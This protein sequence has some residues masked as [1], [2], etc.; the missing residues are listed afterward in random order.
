MTQG[1]LSVEQLEA[2]ESN[3]VAEQQ[4]RRTEAK[5]TYY[6]P[7]ERHATLDLAYCDE[8]P[9]IDVFHEILTRLN[10]TGGPLMLTFTPLLGMSEVVRRFMLEESPQRTIIKMA[11]QDAEHYTDEVRSNIEAQYPEHMR[12]IR[13][14]GIP[15]FGAGLV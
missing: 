4:R 8:E 2:F 7:Y 6:K 9:P 10:V 11:L 15:Q 14:H 3:L 13:A 5:L 12:A 1:P